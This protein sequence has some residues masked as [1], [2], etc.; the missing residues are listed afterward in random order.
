MTTAITVPDP[1][2]LRIGVDGTLQGRS[3]SYDKRL[4]DLHGVYR[5]A[6]EYSVELDRLGADHLAYRVEEHRNLGGEGALVIGTSTVHP[7]TV[8]DELAMTRGHLH[9]KAD[10]AEMYHCLSG[11]GV[12]LLETVDGDS[13]AVPLGAGEAVHVPGHWVHR[14]VNVGTEPF[15]TLFCYAADAGQDYDLIA[16]AGGMSKLVVTAPGGGWTTRPNPDHVGYDGGQ[17]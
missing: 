10:R 3:G 11:N 8:G 4:G 15:V 2:V 1:G 13:R 14:S 7:G 17:R 6:E 9:A 5:D 16:R 12:L